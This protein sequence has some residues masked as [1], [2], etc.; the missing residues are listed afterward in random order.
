MLIAQH[1]VLMREHN[2]IAYELGRINPHWNDERI[3]QV[4]SSASL[5]WLSSLS[6][7][8]RKIFEMIASKQTLILFIL[9]ITHCCQQTLRLLILNI[10]NTTYHGS[11]CSAHH[12]QRIFTD[13]ARQRRHGTLWSSS[14]KRSISITSFGLLRGF[15]CLHLFS[16]AL[17]SS[18][19]RAWI[20]RYQLRFL[21]LRFDSD[22]RS[23][24]GQLNAGV[25]ATNTSVRHWSGTEQSI[26]DVD[27]FLAGA[28]RLSEA[29]L[30]PF[31]FYRGGT[32]DQY[33]SGFMNQVSQA[34]DDSMTQEV[35]KVE[36]LFE[37][38]TDCSRVKQIRQSLIYYLLWTV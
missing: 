10:G 18:I 20:P 16:R 24:R 26:G 33:L 9:Q 37:S 35:S 11:S 29:L 1:T 14:A 25:S 4:V 17:V 27:H 31:D 32:C 7:R 5:F 28:R 34:V 30:K 36:E 38:I 6:A 15:L 19:T 21:R 12:V 2:R 22:T 13:G 3:F 8:E 23:F